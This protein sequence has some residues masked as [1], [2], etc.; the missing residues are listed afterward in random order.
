MAHIPTLGR[1]LN[2]ARQAQRQAGLSARFG[3][4]PEQLQAQQQQQALPQ[5]QSPG[6][7]AQIQV[8]P[9]STFG[10]VQGPPSFA[11]TT[12][13]GP[14]LAAP[15]TGLA[16]S[17]SALFN[18]L[19]A[20]ITALEESVAQGRT[21]VS[22]ANT[23]AQ[24]QLGQGFGQAQ[25]ALGRGTAALQPFVQPGQDAI[26]L[27]A[28]LSGASGAGAQGQAF[29]DFL[30]SPE[31]AFLQERGEQSVLRNAAATGGLGGGRV[32]QEL[33]RQGV[34][35]AA[36][37]FGN[38]FNRL[39][40]VSGLGLQG[41]G[42]IAGLAGQEASIAAQLAGTGAGLQSGAGQSLANLI[43][44]GGLNAA[45]L[46]FQTGQSLSGGRLQAGR[47]IAGAIGGTTSALSDLVNQAGTGAS[48]LLGETG[49]QLANLLAQ[50]GI[51]SGAGQQDL[52]TILANLAAGQGS[53]VA[54]LPGIPGV[55]Q[56]PGALGSI[57]QAAGGIGTLIGALQ[58]T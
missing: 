50:A 36:Q 1:T 34:G 33:Q 25:A 7:V 55:Q 15:A 19:L 3:L 4:T 54:G 22:G 39:G 56:Q 5:V 2:P 44:G 43:S 28:A 13:G 10:P 21:D 20:S 53:T 31:Q 12:P 14:G 57:G 47:D 30:A 48:G 38:Q 35:L 40:Q 9:G 41:A 8:P 18:S 49:G 17:E 23:A 52:A 11:G 27:Q 24:Q 32:L 58:E 16:G 6:G 37:D 45:Q 46:A 29:A 51:T 26:S 42:G